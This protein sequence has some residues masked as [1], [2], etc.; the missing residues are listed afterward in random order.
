MKKKNPESQR[1]AQFG[2]RPETR[3]LKVR[4]DGM[5]PEMGNGKANLVGR[6]TGREKSEDSPA[7]ACGLLKKGTK[8]GREKRRVDVS[9]KS[10]CKTE[11]GRDTYEGI[12]SL[13]DV[14]QFR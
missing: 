10:K 4:Q 13:S 7:D 11:V 3:T 14:P 8:E 12:G 1:G 9:M 5:G 2:Q 6:K